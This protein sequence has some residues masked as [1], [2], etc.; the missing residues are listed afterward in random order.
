MDSCGDSS[1][2]SS[3]LLQMQIPMAEMIPNAPN[4]IFSAS[5]LHNQTEED[6]H[7][8]DTDSETEAKLFLKQPAY[9]ILPMK[10]RKTPKITLVLDLDE[11]LVHSEM[12]KLPHSDH[13]FKIK[14]NQGIHDI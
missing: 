13:A 8:H 4:L 14:L 9:K 12:N 11:T 3:D 6:S 2:I 10:T 1:S 7:T 5:T